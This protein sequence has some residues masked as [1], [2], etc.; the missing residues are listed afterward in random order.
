[1]LRK[2]TVWAAASA[3]ALVPFAA[4]ATDADVAAQLQSMQERLLQLEDKLDATEDSLEAANEKIGAQQDLINQAGLD[5][6]ASSGLSEFVDTLEVGGW[7]SASWFYN[8]RRSE[9]RDLAG[10][11]NGAAGVYPF[12]PDNNSFSL[13]QLWFE[14]ERPVSEEN[15]AGFRADLVYG[16][17]AGLLSGDFGAGDGFS[18]NDFEMYQAYIQYL[19]PI[20]DGVQFNFGKFATVIGAEVVQSPMNFNITRGNVYQFFQPI[21]HTGITASTDI[22]PASV[23]LGLVNETRSF[24]AADIDLNNNKAVLWSAA[25]SDEDSGLG[26]S[27]NGVHGASDSGAGQD[28]FSGDKETILDFILSYDPNENFS[29]YINA[30]WIRTENSVA[31]SVGDTDGYGISA[32]GR[33]AINDRTGFALRAEYIDLSPDNTGNLRIWGLTGTVDYKLTEKLMVR[34]ELRYDQGIGSADEI[35]FR[36]GSS[37]LG[38]PGSGIS[39]SKDDQLV[40]GVEAIY[41]F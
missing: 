25:W 6:G 20:G 21:T 26:F 2:I 34:G 3:I 30:D 5:G 4:A 41:T 1:M 32:A 38:Q 12:S 37:T 19:A 23:T 31:G 29:G 39:A 36:S 13:D 35:F 33:V 40:A 15:R 17:T 28:T 7:V 27:F 24:P 8:T 22:G 9:G 18:G 16:K 14:L 10:Y 11:N